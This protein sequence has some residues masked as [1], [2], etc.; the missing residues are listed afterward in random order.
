MRSHSSGPVSRFGFDRPRAGKKYERG[1]GGN[2][3]YLR[4]RESGAFDRSSHQY[5]AVH[6]SNGISKHPNAARSRSVRGLAERSLS[7]STSSL[8][9]S[10]A[11]SIPPRIRSAGALSRRRTISRLH[12]SRHA[13]PAASASIWSG[14]P[15][16]VTQ[17]TAS[18]STNRC[19]P[20]CI[21]PRSVDGSPRDSEPVS[22]CWASATG[23]TSNLEQVHRRCDAH[24]FN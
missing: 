7:T 6:A 20:H 3:Q 17:S 4:G 18:V 1:F 15:W 2:L 8:S 10:T 11:C 19:W 22:V 13:S 21:R 23:S 14:A 5:V 9:S 16:R 24:A 12:G